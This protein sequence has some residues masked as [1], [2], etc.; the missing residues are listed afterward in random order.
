MNAGLQALVED[1]SPAAT[2]GHPGSHDVCALCHGAHHQGH[3][4]NLQSPHSWE[5]ST[6]FYVLREVQL[7]Y[8]TP[9]LHGLAAV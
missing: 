5:R 3:S 2:F 4:L 6:E 9:R 7:V 1:G 8:P